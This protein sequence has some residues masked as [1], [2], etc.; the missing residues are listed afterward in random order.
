MS[1]EYVC[2]LK[3]L[4]LKFLCSVLQLFFMQ[5]LVGLIQQVT[6]RLKP[7]HTADV[8]Q[9]N[10][11]TPP[12]PEL[13]GCLLLEFDANRKCCCI[14]VDGAHGA[15]LYETL[16][17]TSGIVYIQIFS[18]VLHSNRFKTDNEQAL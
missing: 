10:I 12:N 3:C 9:S 6:G 5:L 13:N 1:L 2:M 17:G 16:S 8:E 14:S 7:S 15:E 11:Q 4:H 18:I